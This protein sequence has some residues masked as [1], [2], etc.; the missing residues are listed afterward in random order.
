M[1]MKSSIVSYDAN[2]TLA[3]IAK[4][5]ETLGQDAVCDGDE[6]VIRFERRK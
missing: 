2:I 1:S 6:R 3:Q 5:A 4:L